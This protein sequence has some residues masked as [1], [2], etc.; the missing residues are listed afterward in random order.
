MYAYAQPQ[1]HAADLFCPHFPIC[2]IFAFKDRKYLVMLMMMM[3]VLASSSSVIVRAHHAVSMSAS[4]H[5][6]PVLGIAID[7]A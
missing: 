4:L 6:L 2:S 1:M 5:L 7:H 3:L